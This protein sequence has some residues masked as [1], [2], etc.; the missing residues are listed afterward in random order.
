MVEARLTFTREELLSTHPALT[1]LVTGGVRCHGGFQPDGTYCSPRTLHRMPAIRAWQS[2]LVAEG[3]DLL[4]IAPALIPPQYPSL[5]QAK[6]LLSEGVREPIVRALTMISIVEGFGAIIRDVAVPDLST[7]VVEP[8]EGTAL[9]HLGVG[10][11][12]AHARDEAGHKDEGGHKQMWEAARD[13]ALDKPKVPGDILMRFMGR[14]RSDDGVERERAEPAIDPALERM[15]VTMTN[16]LVV[17]VFAAR[18]FDWGERLLSDPTVSADPLAAGAMVGYVR[19]DE[20]PHVEYLRTALSEVRARTVRTTA[21]GVV[22][23][24]RVVD[25][26][27]HRTLAALTTSRPR[28]QRENVRGGLVTAIR[29]ARKGDWLI[30]QFDALAPPWVPPALTG[31][32]P[33]ELGLPRL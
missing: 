7:L 1:P 31:F 5:E 20:A 4:A 12:E 18:T 27:L 17:E 16:V 28:D 10:L 9:A 8:I 14:R 26:L 24:R 33:V 6:L 25:A 21:G 11:F 13:L 23:G 29:D 2:R 30:E 19:T 22:P 32:E 15:L 3:H